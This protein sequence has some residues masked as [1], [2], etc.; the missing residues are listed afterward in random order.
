MNNLK[1]RV[2]EELLEEVF[3]L[4]IPILINLEVTGKFQMVY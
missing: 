4:L 2:P 3:G 1:L